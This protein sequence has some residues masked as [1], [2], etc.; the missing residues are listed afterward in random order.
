MFLYTYFAYVALVASLRGCTLAS[1]VRLRLKEEKRQFEEFALMGFLSAVAFVCIRMGRSGN[2]AHILTQ[3]L[4]QN[5][6]Q[7]LSWVKLDNMHLILQPFE[8]NP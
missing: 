4:Q 3:T 8:R 7:G 5:D 2:L 6:K 1:L